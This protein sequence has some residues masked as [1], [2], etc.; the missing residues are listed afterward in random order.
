[1]AKCETIF[2]KFPAARSVL[3]SILLFLFVP[4]LTLCTYESLLLVSGQDPGLPLE[5]TARTPLGPQRG[6][7]R[8]MGAYLQVRCTCLHVHVRHA[9]AHTSIIRTDNPMMYGTSMPRVGVGAAIE[10]STSP[11]LHGCA[12]HHGPMRS[13]SHSCITPSALHILLVSSNSEA[14]RQIPQ[15]P[16][17]L[18]CCAVPCLW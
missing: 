9:H 10:A 5:C 8:A 14:A 11:A 1:M 16:M 7:P 12:L 2:I 6:D 18:S 17:G 3:F 15:R 13:S 4:H